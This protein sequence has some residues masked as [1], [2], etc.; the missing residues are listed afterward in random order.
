S[1]IDHHQPGHGIHGVRANE[2]SRP[3]RPDRPGIHFTILVG[4]QTHDALNPDGVAITL[5]AILR[6]TI[7][8]SSRV[9]QSASRPAASHIPLDRISPVRRPWSRWT[10]S[11]VQ[12][13][14]L[15]EVGRIARSAVRRTDEHPPQVSD[16]NY[17][18]IHC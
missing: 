11:M 13:E 10:L 14:L 5:R 1:A 9:E 8:L 7:K 18:R 6:G 16:L 3:V 17:R 15:T 2:P 4:V 12:T